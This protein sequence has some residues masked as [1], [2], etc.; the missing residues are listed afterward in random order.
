VSEVALTGDAGL[1]DLVDRLLAG[2]VVIHGD[3]V[4]AVAGVDLVHLSLRAMLASVE[5][6]ACPTSTR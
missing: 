6:A 4:L 1:V 5:T 3:V 2:G